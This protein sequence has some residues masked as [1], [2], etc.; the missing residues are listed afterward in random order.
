MPFESTRW[1]FFKEIFVP[2]VVGVVEA[3]GNASSRLWSRWLVDEVLEKH[4][5]KLLEESLQ[6]SR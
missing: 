4:L 6:G 5:V 2:S 3:T 1:D